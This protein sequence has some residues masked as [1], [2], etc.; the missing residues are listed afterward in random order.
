MQIPAHLLNDRYWSGTLHLFI[1][2]YKLQSYLTSKYFDFEEE[3]IDVAAL[4]RI[5]KPWSQSERFML[6]LALSL[7]NARY[8]VQLSDMDYLDST[9]KRLAFEALHRRYG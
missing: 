1:N 4:K 2:H 5:S 7:F 6:S 8:T 9:N 3:T